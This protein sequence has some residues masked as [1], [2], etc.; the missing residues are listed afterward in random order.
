MF[1]G[2]LDGREW[3]GGS[4]QAGRGAGVKCLGGKLLKAVAYEPVRFVHR[5]EA[6]C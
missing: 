6:R 4:G 2:E 1:C 3:V 5:V